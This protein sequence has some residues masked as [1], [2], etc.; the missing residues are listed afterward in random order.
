MAVV[1]IGS[2]AVWT[3]IL[4]APIHCR[5]STEKPGA[6]FGLVDTHLTPETGG[7]EERHGR[8]ANTGTGRRGGLGFARS[9][10][11]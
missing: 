6:K 8:G 9:V 10:S 4:T 5:G 2:T 3:L 1:G 7:V 11:F